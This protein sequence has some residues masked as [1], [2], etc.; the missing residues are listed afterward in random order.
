ML[1]SLV[2]F[3][4]HTFAIQLTPFR[5][6]HFINSTMLIEANSN[7]MLYIERKFPENEENSEIDIEGDSLKEV[8][9]PH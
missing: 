5:I 1:S 2:G 4:N 6:Q 9:L 3:D 7:D 8:I